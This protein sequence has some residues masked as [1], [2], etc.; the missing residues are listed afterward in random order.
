[1][2]FRTAGAIAVLLIGLEGAGG[3]AFAQYYPAPQAY[4]S[5]R[6]LPPVADADKDA[7]VY[8]SPAGRPLPP[9]AVTNEPLPP[10]GAYRDVP[11]GDREMP[12]QGYYRGVPPQAPR[13]YEP[14]ASGTRPYY[15]VP[16]AIP[17]GPAGSAEQDAIR[18]DAMRPPLPISPGQNGP[19]IDPRVTPSM[20]GGDPRGMAAFPPEVRP[21]TG[22]NKELAPQFRRTLV[23][24]R[25]KEPAGTIIVDTPNTYLYLVLGDGKALRYGVGVGRE[26]F[27]WSGA[28]RVTK[29]VEWPDWNPPEEMIVRQPYLPRFMAGG[30]TNPLGARALYLGN[31]IYRIHG[32][33]QPS[34]IGTFV[35]SGCIRLTNEDVMDLYRRVRVGTRVVVLPGRPPAT[36]AATSVASPAPMPSADGS[37]RA[38]PLDPRPSAMAR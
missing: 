24:Y 23:D 22:P 20:Q 21:E 34:T 37:S 17:P 1:M 11:P 38:V 36:A 12:Q 33:N 27:T 3:Q 2:V 14:A 16:G 6:P 10:L 13:A 30:E 5:S 32:T 15:G 19:G 25:T 26:G 8:G 29:I 4:P 28:E 7:P 18:Q 31:T 35:S 9:A